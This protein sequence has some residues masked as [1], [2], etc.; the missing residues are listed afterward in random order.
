[1]D[2]VAYQKEISDWQAWRLTLAGVMLY[3]HV[4]PRWEML[5]VIPA[6]FVVTIAGAGLG[7]ILAVFG[8]R[9]RDLQPAVL[10]VTAILFLFSPVMW[11]AEQLQVNQW[12][13]QYNPFYYLLTLLRDPLL[14]QAPPPWLWLATSIG[15]AVAFVIGF[16][17][18]CASRR[19][20][21]HWL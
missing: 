13:Y 19:R 3:E 15:A 2:A 14:G 4:P 8:A 9:Y 18:F 12:I 1:M 20:L 21:Y 5:Y 10:V 11:N 17:A 16:F 7:L 6:L